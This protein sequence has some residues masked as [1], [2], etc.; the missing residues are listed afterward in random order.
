MAER[1]AGRDSGT[2][3]REQNTVGIVDAAGRPI[4]PKKIRNI[5]EGLLIGFVMLLMMGTGAVVHDMV[6]SM[7]LVHRQEPTQ[8]RMRLIEP[9]QPTSVWFNVPEPIEIKDPDLHRTLRSAVGAWAVA[10]GKPV[11]IPELVTG[12]PGVSCSHSAIACVDTANYRIRLVN[13]KNEDTF[14]IF[15]HEIGHLLGV[16]HINGDPLMKAEY[17]GEMLKEPT[18]FAVA[19]AKIALKNGWKLREDHR[20]IH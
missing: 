19:L 10:L 11:R 2:D 9:I 5:S 7:I 17:S 3:L 18:E 16:P 14:T 4:A 13:L 12:Y 15:L 6:H 8:E 1:E 20:P